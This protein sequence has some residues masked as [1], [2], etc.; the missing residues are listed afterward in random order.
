MYTVNSRM[1]IGAS[2]TQ[3]HG[4]SQHWNEPKRS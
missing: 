2:R 3:R 4:S 1:N